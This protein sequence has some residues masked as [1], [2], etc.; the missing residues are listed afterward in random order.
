M[1]YFISYKK[2]ASGVMTISVYILWLMNKVAL[3][4]VDIPTQ[5]II[6]TLLIYKMVSVDGIHQP[7]KSITYTDLGVLFF[8]V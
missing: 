2:G 3:T 4:R 8:D 5:F 7:Y 6:P 1:V